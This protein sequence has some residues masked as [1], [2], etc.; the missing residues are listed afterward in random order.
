MKP[1]YM[2]P[3]RDPDVTVTW[4]PGGRLSCHICKELFI[5]TSEY[6][7]SHWAIHGCPDC[8][9]AYCD[10][11]AALLLTAYTAE[12]WDLVFA[13]AAPWRTRPRRS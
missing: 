7:A 9:E 6:P 11:A 13:G 12:E 3:A 2:K 1:V 4:F 8:L 10:R 5:C